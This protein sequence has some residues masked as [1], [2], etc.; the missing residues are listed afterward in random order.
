MTKFNKTLDGR[1]AAEGMSGAP[2]PRAKGTTDFRTPKSGGRPKPKSTVN[3][4]PK[5]K[6]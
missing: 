1:V 5:T 3:F 6:A 4:M 2:V